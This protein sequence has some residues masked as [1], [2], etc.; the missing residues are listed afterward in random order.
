MGI[1]PCKIRTCI[2]IA[3]SLRN[4]KQPW[5]AIQLAELAYEMAKA[6]IDHPVKS[7]RPNK[8]LLDM[9]KD[10]CLELGVRLWEDS[11]AADNEKK[12]IARLA[13][14]KEKADERRAIKRITNG[15]KRPAKVARSKRPAY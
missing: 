14:R 15:G 10:L 2:D 1:A 7:I 6:Q 11:P 3:I 8:F 9:A 12:C 13:K 5:T 4:D